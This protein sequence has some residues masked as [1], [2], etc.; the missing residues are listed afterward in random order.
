M[1]RRPVTGSEWNGSWL[2]VFGTDLAP[3]EIMIA[4]D[5]LMALSSRLCTATVAFLVVA[6]ISTSASLMS[7]PPIQ[8]IAA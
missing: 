5:L 8:P 7:L 2:A 6:P 4:R 3:S 1:L